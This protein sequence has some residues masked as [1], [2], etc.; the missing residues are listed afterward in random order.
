VSHAEAPSSIAFMLRHYYSLY[1]LSIPSAYKW[2][3]LSNG[4]ISYAVMVESIGEELGICHSVSTQPSEPLVKIIEEL[5]EEVGNEV[6]KDVK[7]YSCSE[8]ALVIKRLVKLTEE[9]KLFE[10]FDKALLTLTRFYAMLISIILQR[11][12]IPISTIA[13]VYD[14]LGDTRRSRANL[15]RLLG[16]I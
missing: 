13:N 7:S 1:D 9:G 11:Y 6:V 16:E 8:I 14:R 15:S 12:R 10:D 3:P 4:L 2:L 5:A